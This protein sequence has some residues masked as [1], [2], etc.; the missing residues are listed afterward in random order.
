MLNHKLFFFFCFFL[1]SLFSLHAEAKNNFTL[2]TDTIKLLF[3]GDTHFVWGVED[4][5]NEGIS[6]IENLLPI[7]ENVHF[8]ALNI[9]TVF[10]LNSKSLVGRAYVFNSSIK[11][12]EFLRKLKINL[13]FLGNNHT[14]D[15]GEKGLLETIENLKNHQIPT[16]GAGKNIEEALTPYV[17]NIENISFAF[18]SISLIGLNDD[19]ANIK[20]GGIATYNKLLLN[21]ILETRKK[22]NYI[23]VSIHWGKEYQPIISN[24]Q[25]TIAKTLID[26]GVN[27]II[28][29]HTHIPQS[30]V[31]NQNN[32]VLYSL[33]NF[34]FGSSNYFQSNNILAIFHFNPKSK[35]FLGIEII[36][37]SG[38]NRKNHFK[39]SVLD[40]KES[41]KLFK[42]LYVLSQKEQANQKVFINIQMNR[43]FFSALD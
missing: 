30:I 26:N 12:I 40:K 3:A 14:Y 13:G 7:F 15:H 11:N 35:Q 29:H 32:A 37:I 41:L 24:E 16:I 8:R 25:R 28:G 43:L 4:V 38:I 27:F 36:P 31:V 1:L 33:G 17:I 2:P 6:P 9:E 10:S 18:F 22:V 23:F 20:K 42:E 34:L 21:K 19:I 5:I 39:I